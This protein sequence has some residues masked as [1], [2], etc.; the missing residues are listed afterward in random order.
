MKL[1]FLESLLNIGVRKEF[2]TETVRQYRQVNAL[3]VFY[4][5]V[6][7]TAGFLLYYL[8]P[9]V[10]YS[11][12]SLI[13]TLTYL[14]GFVLTKNNKLQAAKYL[15]I[16]AFEIQVFI[17]TMTMITGFESGVRYSYTLPLLILYPLLASLVEVSIPLH[18]CVAV[19]QVVLFFTLASESRQL[20]GWVLPSIVFKNDLIVI[21]NSIL[22][23]IIEAATIISIIRQEYIRA[24]KETQK[25]IVLREELTKKIEAEVE[26]RK[27]DIDKR[28]EAVKEKEKAESNTH[29]HNKSFTGICIRLGD[30][31]SVIM[32][33]IEN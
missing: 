1:S 32:V 19:V 27:I 28:A 8:Q 20:F 17:I 3:N 2:D 5:F 21:M 23:P 31:G 26:A 24:Q 14:L 22:Y 6:A 10:F 15:V 7:F 16:Y 30:C 12:A 18:A 25:E 11:V 33:I 4:T 29:P 9:S 13:F